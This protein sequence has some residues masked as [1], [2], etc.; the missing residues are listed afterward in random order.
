MS[1]SKDLF[2]DAFR[3]FS[4]WSLEEYQARFL[5]RLPYRFVQGAVIAN[6]ALSEI[7]GFVDLCNLF[8]SQVGRRWRNPELYPHLNRLLIPNYPYLQQHIDALLI[9]VGMQELAPSSGSTSRFWRVRD[10]SI[11]VTEIREGLLREV[12][13]ALVPTTHSGPFPLLYRPFPGLFDDVESRLYRGSDPD[14]RTAAELSELSVRAL[15]II[16]GYSHEMAV[17]FCEHVGTVAFMPPSKDA[18]SFSLRNYYIGGIF[19]SIAD[20]ILLA[21]QFI[22]EYYHQRIWPWWLVDAPA[23][24]PSD[25]Q[26][27]LSPVTGRTRPISVMVQAL[28]IYVSLVDFYRHVLRGSGNDV[29]MSCDMSRARQRLTHL[30]AGVAPLRDTL[31]AGLVNC[32]GT[33][34]LVDFIA[35]LAP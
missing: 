17:A 29:P 32:P 14:N 8:A 33:H 23:D 15:E 11:A 30:E 27:V 12:D 5:G 31:R 6:P 3:A 34:S 20:P 4:R 35:N 19:V 18:K 1:A 7:A 21:E 16:D 28:L 9:H 10:R 25:E 2:V 24:M 26:V 22:H 13:D